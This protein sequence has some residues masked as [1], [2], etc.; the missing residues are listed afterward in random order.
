VDEESVFEECPE[1]GPEQDVVQDHNAYVQWDM[2]SGVQVLVMELAC[3][4]WKVA[5]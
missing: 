2:A 1:H 3:G 5:K 4:C